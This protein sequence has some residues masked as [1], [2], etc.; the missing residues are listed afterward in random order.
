MFL[1]QKKDKKLSRAIMMY[2]VLQDLNFTIKS[3]FSLADTPIASIISIGIGLI[4][5]FIFVKNAKILLER[6]KTIIRKSYL[7]FIAIYLISCLFAINRGEPYGVILKE[8][9]LWTL[10]FWIPIGLFAYSV[11]DKRILYDEVYKLS[12]VRSAILLFYFVW[13]V[14]AG[15]HMDDS[16]TDYS[17][18]FSY[19]LIL[20]L[21]L[22]IDK[23]LRGFTWPLFLL[24]SVELTAILILGSRGTLLC[25]ITYFLLRFLFEKST[26][27]QN[28]RN[29]FLLAVFVAILAVIGRNM[30]FLNSVGLS[31]RILT[32]ADAG[33]VTNL[34]GRDELWTKTLLMI[35]EKPLLGYGLG[36]EYHTLSVFSYMMGWTEE[37]IISSTS[38]HN[39]FLEM[40]V[41]FGIPFG[42]FVSFYI[43]SRIFFVR[44]TKDIV[45]KNFAIILFS[46]YIIPSFTVG[47]G[48][49]IKP[50]IAFF[51]YLMISLKKQYEQN[52]FNLHKGVSS[53]A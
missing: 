41:C 9:A 29:V 24:V 26:N 4:I 32:Y 11:S 8:S 5:A 42:V 52:Q 27:K 48:V 36:G 51:I 25:L 53:A 21:L 7:L 33:E 1:S 3:C 49:F 46:V 2:F 31:S 34:S 16:Q 12:Y 13:N 37:L 39:G 15:I 40:L 19:A 43:V 35:S 20:P 44:K 18:Y 14:I 38:P 10:F 6:S 45:I 17:M 50:G 28:I 47:D 23:L 22:H 30:D